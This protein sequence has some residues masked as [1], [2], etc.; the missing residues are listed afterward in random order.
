VYTFTKLNDRR[1]PI[2]SAHSLCVILFHTLN[3][4]SARLSHSRTSWSAVMT[5]HPPHHAK[6]RLRQSYYD[7]S[8]RGRR[9]ANVVCIWTS[10]CQTRSHDRYRYLVV[11]QVC[12]VVAH[13]E[14][15]VCCRV[16]HWLFVTMCVWTI[17]F[18]QNDRAPVAYR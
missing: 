6:L 4:R 16:K 7:S 3:C 10:V 12:Y 13:Y 11:L 17:T 5:G 14:V 2:F 18:E 9:A 15:T 8:K 1:I